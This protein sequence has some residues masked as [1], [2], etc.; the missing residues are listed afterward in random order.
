MKNAEAP[1]PE[2]FSDKVERIRREWDQ[3]LSKND[4]QALLAL[5]SARD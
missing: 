5:H 1:N 2:P 3:A 4:A